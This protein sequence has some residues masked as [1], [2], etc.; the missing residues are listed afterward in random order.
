[1]EVTTMRAST[2][3]DERALRGASSLSKR[4]DVLLARLASSGAGSGLP[5]LLSYRGGNSYG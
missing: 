2:V 1:V 3:T 4:H 5:A